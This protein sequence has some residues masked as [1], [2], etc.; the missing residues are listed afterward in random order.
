MHLAQDFLEKYEQNYQVNEESLHA[1]SPVLANPEVY[2]R[3]PSTKPPS[4][5]L[6]YLFDNVRH[7]HQ[8]L[9]KG[10]DRDTD[11]LLHHLRAPKHLVRAFPWRDPE[12]YPSTVYYSASGQRLEQEHPMR[13]THRSEVEPQGQQESGIGDRSFSGRKSVTVTRIG[14]T[15]H[16][17]EHLGLSDEEFEEEEEVALPQ[18]SGGGN[19]PNTPRATLSVPTPFKTPNQFFLPRSPSSMSREFQIPGPNLPDP[20]RGMA[21]SSYRLPMD[22]I[23][24]VMKSHW[25][26]MRQDPRYQNW[27]SLQPT[28]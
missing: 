28:S 14:H 20:L 12:D 13:Y 10:Y 18:R 8:Q 9:P 7:Y 25:M 22:S 5:Q 21:S 2:N 26:Q 6:M 19:S 3:W 23:S 4:V 27:S 24:Q 11:D 17:V 15:D 16:V 1:T